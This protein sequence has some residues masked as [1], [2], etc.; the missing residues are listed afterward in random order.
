MIWREGIKY[1]RE[2]LTDKIIL[3][4]IVRAWKETPQYIESSKGRR[5]IGV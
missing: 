1:L 2:D 4:E 5:A 3:A